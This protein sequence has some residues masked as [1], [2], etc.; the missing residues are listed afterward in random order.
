MTLREIIFDIKETFNTYSDDSLLENEH[1]AFIIN[2]KRAAYLRNLISNL[3]REVPG[4]AKQLICL[5]LIHDELCEAD[6]L[7]LRSEFPIPPTIE[8]TGRSNITEAYL[9]SRLAK[10]INI[11]DYQRIPYLASGRFNNNQIYIA[12]DPNNYLILLSNSGNHELLKEIKLFIVA[13][14]PEEADAFN[15]NSTDET[16]DFYDKQY[17]IEL[18]MINDIKREML[19]ELL[20][21]Y[22]LPVDTIND[23][24][25]NT[26]NKNPL[27]VNTRR[28]ARQ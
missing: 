11:V 20:I 27:D 26:V 12:I 2:T 19:N 14:N 18:S 22:R 9:N 1:L 10:W 17:P 15:C 7:F 28:T 24:E 16:C 21:K 13:E 5:N 25:D 4:Q 6:I 23:A 3:K 8:S